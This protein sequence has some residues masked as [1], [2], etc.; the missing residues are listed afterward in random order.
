MQNKTKR[1]DSGEA[2]DLRR[3]TVVGKIIVK[4]AHNLVVKKC[5]IL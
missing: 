2:P 1:K 3:K 5:G 4:L